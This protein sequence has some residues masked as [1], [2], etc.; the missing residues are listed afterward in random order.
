MSVKI[1]ALC[2][3]L[4]A[5]LAAAKLEIP[6]Q[7]KQPPSAEVDD[8]DPYVILIS[9]CRILVW[10]TMLA[11]VFTQAAMWLPTTLRSTGV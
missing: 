11:T 9:F 7:F 4:V 10:I 2:S 8:V 1:A 6:P 5:S 3:V